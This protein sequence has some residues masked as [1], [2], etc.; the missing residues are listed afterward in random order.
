MP[1]HLLTAEIYQLRVGRRQNDHKS[2]Y[3]RILKGLFQLQLFIST[4]DNKGKISIGKNQFVI[5]CFPHSAS[6]AQAKTKI[7]TLGVKNLTTI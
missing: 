5:V 3:F 1:N 2:G 6:S 7:P 4:F